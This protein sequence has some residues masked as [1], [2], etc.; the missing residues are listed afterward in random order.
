M[1]PSLATQTFELISPENGAVIPVASTIMTWTQ[2]PEA[3][4]YL[5]QI[6]Q[7]VDFKQT[8]FEYATTVNQVTSNYAFASGE[9]YW[10]VVAL[11]NGKPL[12][13]TAPRKF[14]RQ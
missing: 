7:D 8:L 4:S 12:K 10:Q 1:P 13:V 9:Y 2:V 11:S 3:T 5:V 6:A 14:L